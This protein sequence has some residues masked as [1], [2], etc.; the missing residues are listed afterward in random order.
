MGRWMA[1]L[2]LAML[3]AA[4]RAADP[5]P[6]DDL[7]AELENLPPRASYEAGVAVTY[8]DITYWRSNTG[9]WMGFGLRGGFGWHFGELHAHRV[10]PGLHLTLE[11][12]APEYFTGAIEPTFAWDFVTKGLYLGAAVGPAVLA[13]SR[14]TLLGQETSWALSPM[15]AARVGWSQ[16]WS[17]LTRRMYVVVEPK[18]RWIDENPNWG[19]ALV[20][21]SGRGF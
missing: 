1:F 4:A 7:W 9:P 8:G 13:H 18:F 20:V 15:V 11:G 12:P 16:P 6:E 5:A 19:A 10:G 2:L 3:P 14:L 21:G 17:R